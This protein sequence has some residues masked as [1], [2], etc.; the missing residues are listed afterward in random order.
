MIDVQEAVGMQFGRLNFAINRM[1]C[2]SVSEIGMVRSL[3]VH[4]RHFLL[5][6]LFVMV[7]CALMMTSR[8]V[9]SQFTS[10]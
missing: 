1:L 10:R 5:R 4:P 2:V 3:L 9:V 6:R 8:T 7:S